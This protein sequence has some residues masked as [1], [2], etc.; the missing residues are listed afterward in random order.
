MILCLSL[1]FQNFTKICLGVSL[2]SSIVLGIRLALTTSRSE[3]F[4]S[5]GKFSSINKWNF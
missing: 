4:F 1:E 2:F 5:S 3:S